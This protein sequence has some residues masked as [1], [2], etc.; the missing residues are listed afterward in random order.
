MFRSRDIVRTAVKASTSFWPSQSFCA[1]I[2]ICYFHASQNCSL[3]LPKLFHPTLIKGN[4]LRCVVISVDINAAT[5]R[6]MMIYNYHIFCVNRTMKLH[7][8]QLFR[9]LGLKKT[10]RGVLPMWHTMLLLEVVSTVTIAGAPTYA[11]IGDIK[12]SPL[13]PHVYPVRSI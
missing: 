2:S 11:T 8:W 7:R 1:S 6:L 9:E 12:A 13:Q 5:W 10:R 3:H 4:F